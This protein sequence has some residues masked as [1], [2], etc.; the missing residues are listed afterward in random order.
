MQILQLTLPQDMYQQHIS[1]ASEVKSTV[2]FSSPRSMS[3]EKTKADVDR[4]ASPIFTQSNI[5]S[6]F[7]PLGLLPHLWSFWE[8]LMTGKDI[9]IV[10]EQ[11]SLCSEVA[12]ALSGLAQ[13]NGFQGELWP[14]ISSRGSDADDI[15]R[16]L[17][18]KNKSFD[19]AVVQSK[20]GSSK[21]KSNYKDLLNRPRRS[22]IIGITNPS[23][24][25]K[26]G[27]V[28]AV[29]FASPSPVAMFGLRRYSSKLSAAMRLYKGGDS[30]TSPGDF[31]L[32]SYKLWARGLQRIHAGADKREVSTMF[33]VLEEP[34]S[35]EQQRITNRLRKLSKND[36]LALGSILLRDHFAELTRAFHKPLE[37]SK[38]VSAVPEVVEEPKVAPT[39]VIPPRKVEEAPRTELTGAASVKDWVDDN[40]PTVILYA[41][42]AAGIIL[43]MLVRLPLLPLIVLV[44]FVQI[45]ARAPRAFELFL[46]QYIPESVLFPN[47]KTGAAPTAAAPSAAAVASTPAPVVVQSAPAPSNKDVVKTDFS[48]VWK[49]VKTINF[50]TF[51]GAQG[52]SYVQRKLAASMPLTHTLTMNPDRLDAFRFQVFSL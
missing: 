34:S 6:V 24:I 7:G 12:I 42:I 39:I 15:G 43:Y 19:D 8:L 13:P 5:I 17:T 50:D 27:E 4:G 45:P 14:Y 31:Y 20:K 36:F 22:M 23:L 9:I 40:R 51:V 37:T 25:K 46:A 29:I 44:Y 10:S 18:D 30:F 35:G 3:V 21:S 41:L 38:E 1:V 33:A 11:P 32:S 16:A 52:A 26:L 47:K 49:R 48:G 2:P 28:A